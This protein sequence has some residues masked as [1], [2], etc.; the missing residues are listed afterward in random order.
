MSLVSCTPFLALLALAVGPVAPSP[1]AGPD[2]VYV[3]GNYSQLWVMNQDGS[4]KTRILNKSNALLNSP[5]WSP[6]GSEIAFV[7]RINGSSG[8]WAI[9]S[10]GTNLRQIVA[11]AAFPWY[12]SWSP[13]ATA[14]GSE[15]IAYLGA[16]GDIFLVRPDG[17]GV[18]QLTTGGGFG[19]LDWS[20]DGGRLTT[21]RGTYN[22]WVLDVG[23]VA[24][25]PV[26]TGMTSVH[27]GSGG[28]P[29][30][31]PRWD[32]DDSRI[33]FVA[34]SDVAWVDATL[35]NGPL[36]FVT[37]TPSLMEEHLGEPSPDGTRL[38][39][40]RVASNQYN[41][42]TFDLNGGGETLLATKACKPNWRR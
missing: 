39:Y 13:V 33:F 28:G 6:D 11:S 5:C 12:A 9:R 14:D 1:A 31:A 21:S 19:P 32:A 10:N 24:G 29:I 41:V 7:A 40:A 34:N 37:Y 4:G 22:I 35:T 30:P 18:V 38:T 27:T 16:G 2:I 8:V 42:Y 36:H 25:Q 23:A 26:L 3:N 17:T 15:R 20:S